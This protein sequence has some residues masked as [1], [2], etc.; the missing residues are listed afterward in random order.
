MDKKFNI[1]HIV[2]ADFK[3]KVLQPVPEGTAS[4]ILE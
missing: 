3:K 1:L 4:I 2:G